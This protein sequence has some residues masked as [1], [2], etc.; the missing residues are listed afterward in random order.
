MWV[1]A[2]L[3]KGNN[4][5]WDLHVPGHR[6]AD[7][8]PLGWAHTV[9]PR[10]SSQASLRQT[11]SQPAAWA[12]ADLSVFGRQFYRQKMCICLEA[13]LGGGGHLMALLSL[14]ELLWSLQLVVYFLDSSRTLLFFSPLLTAGRLTLAVISSSPAVS[15]TS[16]RSTRDVSVRNLS[17]KSTL[18]SSRRSAESVASTPK[19]TAWE[20]RPP[21]V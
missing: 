3:G 1:F 4:S 17:T 8:E 12:P 19:R 14:T 13:E 11:H 2:I 6:L 15:S 10:G 16:T 18:I 9:D 21:N 5:Q 7:W 20:Y